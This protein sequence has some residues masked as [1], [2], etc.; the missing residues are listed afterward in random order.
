MISRRVLLALLTALGLFVGVWAAVVPQTF[1]A[2]FPGLGFGSWVSGDGAFNEHLI[3]DVGELNLA[4]AAA[5][6]VAILARTPPTAT[7]AARV[8]AVAWLVYSL[9]HLS[10]HLTHLSG[11]ATVD[12]IAEP[13]ALSLSI[14]LSIPLLIGERR[15]RSI[16]TAE[17]SSTITKES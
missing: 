10:Y 4:L 7:V 15:A 5:G 9:P 16:P 14:V 2:G 3:R 13:L 12:A 1:Y 17:T 11:F 8:V 6:I